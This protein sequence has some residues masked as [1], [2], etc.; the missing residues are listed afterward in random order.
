MPK[1]IYGKGNYRS[2]KRFQRNRSYHRDVLRNAGAGKATK[3]AADA[4]DLAVFKGVGF[5][6]RL[7]MKMLY[8]DLTGQW[9]VSA[10][11]NPYANG[12]YYINSLWD[13]DSR[14]LSG[15]PARF[16]AISSI[17]SKYRVLGVKYEVTMVNN[18]TMPLAVGVVCTQNTTFSAASATGYAE[19]EGSRRDVIL[20]KGSGGEKKTFRGY[21]N[22]GEIYG[23]PLQY[24]TDDLT[25]GDSGHSPTSIIYLLPWFH[26][27]NGA[28]FVTSPTLICRFTLYCE[29]FDL[30]PTQQ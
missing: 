27:V 20:A 30:I 15:S 28:N 13:M 8:Q 21:Y 10:G 12:L 4:K 9:T 14:V 24:V 19:F 16:A 17:Y 1:K 5:P 25:M 26:T 29:W 22:L 11:A 7:R 18:D 3:G 6:R 2:T 23:N